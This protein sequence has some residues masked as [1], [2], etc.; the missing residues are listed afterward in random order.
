MHIVRSG[1]YSRSHDS[2]AIFRVR[3]GAVELGG[4]FRSSGASLKSRDRG[5][6]R[7]TIEK[8]FTEINSGIY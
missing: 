6:Q 2:Y 8:T 5:E 7:K 1:L 4:C 3:E